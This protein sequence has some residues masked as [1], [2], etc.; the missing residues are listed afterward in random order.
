M[1]ITTQ[2]SYNHTP[3][4]VWL[5]FNAKYRWKWWRSRQKRTTSRHALHLDVPTC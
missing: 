5:H 1:R 2:A 4:E 3:Y